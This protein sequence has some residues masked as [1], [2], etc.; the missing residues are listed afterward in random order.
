MRRL[1]SRA[2][3]HITQTEAIMSETLQLICE[4]TC[5]PNLKDIDSQIGK[6]KKYDENPV[7]GPWL[8][9]QQRTLRYTEHVMIQDHVAR[10]LTCWRTRV[11]G[12]G[13][14]LPAEQS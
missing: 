5:N 3:L 1:Y 14:P 9:A 12:G 6:H 8:W 11:Y 10:C 2:L 7:G 4:G 13:R